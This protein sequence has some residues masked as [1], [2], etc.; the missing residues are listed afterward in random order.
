MD[1]LFLVVMNEGGEYYSGEYLAVALWATSP[2]A[3]REY[4]SKLAF[5][6]ARIHG[7]HVCLRLCSGREI[8]VSCKDVFL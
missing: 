7:G 3:A 1:D 2:D 5:D 4:R 6:D 8:A